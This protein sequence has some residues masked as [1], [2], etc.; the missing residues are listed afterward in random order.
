MHTLRHKNVLQLLGVYTGSQPFWI[1]TECMARGS[2]LDY[3]RKENQQTLK[4]EDL[5]G[6]ASQVLFMLCFR[7]KGKDKRSDAVI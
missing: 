7:L 4:F 3:L 2:L 1:I 6:I 5:V